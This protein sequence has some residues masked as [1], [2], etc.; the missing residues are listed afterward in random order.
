LAV[1]PIGHGLSSILQEANQLSIR[2]REDLRILSDDSFEFNTFLS[3]SIRYKDIG[4][5]DFN[6]KYKVTPGVNR[7]LTSFPDK[8][9]KTRTVAIFDY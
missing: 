3:S 7:R 6:K 9:G 2:Q 1:G 4:L 8:E 5:T